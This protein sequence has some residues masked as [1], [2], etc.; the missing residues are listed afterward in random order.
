MEFLG[1]GS[2]S[3]S[4]CES[5]SDEVVEKTTGPPES[6]KKHT[7][8]WQESDSEDEDSAATSVHNKG[9]ADRVSNSTSS[10]FPSALDLLSAKEIPSFMQHCYSEPITLKEKTIEM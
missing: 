3:D 10:L 6:A 7:F 4:D 5:D 8:A 2:D 1:S 9:T